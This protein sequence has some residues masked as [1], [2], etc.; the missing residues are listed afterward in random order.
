MNSIITLNR[1][2][3]LIARASGKR[4]AEVEPFLKAFMET[5]KEA[6]ASDEVLTVKG[7]GTFTVEEARGERKIM[8]QADE[9]LAKAVNDPFSMFEPEELAPGASIESLDIDIIIDD[10]IPASEPAPKQESQEGSEGSE[11]SEG[12]EISENSENSEASEKSEASEN[13]EGTEGS[14]GFKSSK[15]PY[16]PN[17]SADIETIAEEEP[18]SASFAEPLEPA[19]PEKPKTSLAAAYNPPP[20]SKPDEAE[21]ENEYEEAYDEEYY[22]EDARGKFPTFWATWAAI[23][24]LLI[25]LAIGFFAH[26]PICELLEPTAT[27]QDLDEAEDTEEQSPSIDPFIEETEPQ[28]TTEETAAQ[29]ESPKEEA[30]VYDTITER[31]F[32]THLAQKH[33]HQKDYWVYIYLE[34]KDIIGNPNTVKAGTRVKIPPL[35]KYAKHSSEA[36]NLKEAKA[37]AAKI[38]K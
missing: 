31:T 19:V 9:D 33:Y 22:E 3:E 26:D 18:F 30:D 13:S 8:F 5:A 23:I 29:Q 38:T 6:I 27:E 37:L 36:E 10:I 17:L 15:S 21:E 20:I 28:T 35:S 2:A 1:L 12:S 4:T 16:A 24:G 25:G 34:N 7:I 32:L 11:A 14:E